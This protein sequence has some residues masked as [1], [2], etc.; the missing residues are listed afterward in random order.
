MIVIMFYCFCK[1]PSESD[2]K[3]KRAAEATVTHIYTQGHHQ[4]EVVKKPGQA[5]QFTVRPA[6]ATMEQTPGMIGPYQMNTTGQPHLA[7]AYPQMP[8]QPM[9]PTP[10]PAPIAISDSR[11]IPPATAPAPILTTTPQFQ[12]AQGLMQH[13]Q[14]S[15][16]PRSTFVMSVGENDQ[17]NSQQQEVK[18]GH[19]QLVLWVAL[20]ILRHQR[21]NPC[22]HCLLK[23][24]CQA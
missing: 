17:S 8:G 12:S 13:L 21:D 3:N 2:D 22:R 23:E 20:S 9:Y 10:Q 6:E 14:S 19:C 11:T 18:T 4:T 15:S 5:T 16:H 7:G 24:L 1:W